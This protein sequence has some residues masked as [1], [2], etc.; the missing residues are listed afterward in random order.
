MRGQSS[1]HVAALL[2]KADAHSPRMAAPIAASLTTGARIGERL[3]L[4][5]ARLQR[6][7]TTTTSG[8]G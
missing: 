8:K 6:R 3:S 7:V 5:P 1:P 4:T 2:P